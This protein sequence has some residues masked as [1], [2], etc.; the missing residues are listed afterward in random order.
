M[1]VWMKRSASPVGLW[2]TR[3]AA[4]LPDLRA[5]RDGAEDVRHISAAV[6]REHAFDADPPGKP[7]NRAA[8]ERGRCLAS[9]IRQ[10]LDVGGATVIVDGGVRVLVASALDGLAP[11]AMHAARSRRRCTPWRS[12][13][14]R[15]RT[16][17][18]DS[19]GAT[20]TWR[21]GP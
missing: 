15:A 4:N 13:R 9:L 11:V 10:D 7:A 21:L 17:C 3:S 5:R 2:M 6:V 16:N 20:W 12:T 18:A 8:Q 14:G 19:S 1:R